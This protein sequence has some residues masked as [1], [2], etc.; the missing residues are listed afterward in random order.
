MSL[1]VS[2]PR[3]RRFPRVVSRLSPL[4]FALSS[5]RESRHPRTRVV[6]SPR[7]ASH[8]VEITHESHV[9]PE[10]GLVVHRR[11]E[12]GP[13]QGRVILVLR[14]RDVPSSLH[15]PPS[16]DA[17]ERRRARETTERS[18]ALARSPRPLAP[19]RASLRRPGAHACM[20]RTPFPS[21]SLVASFSLFHAVGRH[22]LLFHRS[23]PI[24]DPLCR[25]RPALDLDLG[26]TRGTC[27]IITSHDSS[28]S[29]L[30]THRR[31]YSRRAVSCHS[32]HSIHFMHSFIP[33]E[34]S[35]GRRRVRRRSSMSSISSRRRTA[36]GRDDRPARSS[37]VMGLS[38]R[39]CLSLS[40]ARCLSLAMSLSR[41]RAR[42]RHRRR[43][44]VLL[45]VLERVLERAH[46]S[47][48]ARTN[49]RTH[50]FMHSFMHPRIIGADIATTSRMDLEGC[51]TRDV[52]TRRRR[53]SRDARERGERERREVSISESRDRGR[54]RTATPRRRFDSIRFR[55]LI[56]I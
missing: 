13:K 10:L 38:R 27:A 42:A 44:R 55:H 48:H 12:Q 54:R 22:D 18:P 4:P 16:V 53:A 33:L 34:V 2:H 21:F 5:P 7:I 35:V 50:P 46:A 26:W 51:A 8:R 45:S 49:A 1:T 3:T 9:L 19:A 37:A 56:L 23:R 32:F 36:T 11:L 29:R 47:T 52:V 24:G 15:R 39:A 41:S 25:P 40:R 31:E 43:V 17:R 28:W 30:C 20:H 6:P 14:H